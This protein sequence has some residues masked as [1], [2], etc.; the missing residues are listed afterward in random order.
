MQGYKAWITRE[1]GGG[2]GQHGMAI[3][4]C[5]CAWSDV[6]ETGGGLWGG[7]S[8]WGNWGRRRGVKYLTA[9][10]CC[11]TT[12]GAA[13]DIHRDGA[14]WDGMGWEWRGHVIE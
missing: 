1:A 2:W 10:F 9:G 8:N 5:V 14:G 3:V 4:F 13:P 12:G 11:F 6:P 7:E